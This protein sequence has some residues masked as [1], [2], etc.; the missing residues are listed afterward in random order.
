MKSFKK[1]SE[2]VKLPNGKFKKR[3]PG[4]KRGKKMKP[5]EKV[6]RIQ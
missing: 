4:S 5:K 3:E 6:K 2:R 1:D